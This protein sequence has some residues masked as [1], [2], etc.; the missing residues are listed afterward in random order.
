MKRTRW[1][2]ITVV[3]LA[4]TLTALAGDLLHNPRMVQKLGLTKE[5][6]AKLEDL[7]YKNRALMINLRADAQLKRLDIKREMSNDNP[8][9]AALDKLVDDMTAIRGKMAKAKIDHLLAVRRILTPEQWTELR[10]L[11]VSMKGREHSRWG[12]MGCSRRYRRGMGP[13]AMNG[14][15]PQGPPDSQRG[16]FH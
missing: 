1:I 7:N 14:A 12:R 8:N 5:Q 10:E 3:V 9:E 6:T 4:V 13:G 2:G 11:M 16:D 15:S